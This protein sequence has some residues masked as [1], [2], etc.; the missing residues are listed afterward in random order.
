VVLATPPGS[1]EEEDDEPISDEEEEAPEIKEGTY[2]NRGRCKGVA[3]DRERGKDTGE[4]GGD[5]RR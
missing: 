1:E 2:L 5:R 4:I 3:G